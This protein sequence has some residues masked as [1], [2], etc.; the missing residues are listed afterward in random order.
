MWVNVDDEGAEWVEQADA[1]LKLRQDWI[2][3]LNSEV[4]EGLRPCSRF[5]YVSGLQRLRYL[6]DPQAFAPY[7]KEVSPDLQHL[8]L[9][10]AIITSDK[11]AGIL[12]VIRRF[13]QLRSFDYNASR[14][15]AQLTS[16]DVLATSP[17][18]KESP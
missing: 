9:R 14:E 7:M 1:R 10:R 4:Q 11:E 17:G 6:G 13:R 5:F 2:Y 16:A 15:T 3:I 12:D 8:D 18:Q